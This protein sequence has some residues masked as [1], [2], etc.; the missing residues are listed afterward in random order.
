MISLVAPVYNTRT[1]YLADLLASFREQNIAGRTA[2][3]FELVL[4]DD[5]SSDARTQA[6]LDRH[7][8]EPHLRIIRNGANGG[9]AAATNAGIAGARGEWIALIDHDDAIAPF[10]LEQIA[11]ALLDHPETEFLYTD[12]VITDGR[13]DPEGYF[14]KPAWDEVLLSG[15][16]YIN[17]FSVYRRSRLAS[18]GGLRLGFDGSQDYDLLLRYTRDL[19]ATQIRHLPYPAYLWRRDGA[20]Y[21]VQFMDKATTRAR[22]ALQER[23]GSPD[24]VLDVLPALDP[25]LHRLDLAGARDFWP[26]VSIVIPSRNARALITQVMSG[27]LEKTDYPSMEIIIVDNGSDDPEVLA[28]YERWRGGARPFRAEIRPEPFNFS[29]AVNRGCALATGDV[30]LLLNNDIEIQDPGWLKEMVSCLAFPQTGIVGAKLLYPDRTLQ[31]AGVIAGLGGLAGHWFIGEKRDFPG[32]MGRLFVRQ[33]LSVV[34]GACFLISRECWEAVGPFDEEK[35]AIAYNDVDF[36]LRA[37]EKGFRVVWTPFAEMIHHES[38][39]RGSDETPQNIERFRREQD[40]LRA[41]H[42]TDVLVDRAFNPWWTRG[43]SRPDFEA[44]DALPPAR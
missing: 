25:N 18:I 34:T 30:I 15:M 36:C 28:L 38:A 43:Y 21:S 41:R 16:N 23:F 20:S 17:H 31:H 32:P 3:L 14:L 11:A 2:G 13:L 8:A 29:R 24:R 26:S 44:I 5:G 40:N 7:A 1:A 9:I 19:S 12:E 35:F 37:V 39:S 10:A 27:L 6:W 42:R 4:S 22:R 33:S